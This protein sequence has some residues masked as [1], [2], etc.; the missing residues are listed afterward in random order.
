MFSPYVVSLEGSF[1]KIAIICSSK[2]EDNGGRRQHS[3]TIFKSGTIS[4]K[5]N[6]FTLES[7]VIGMFTVGLKVG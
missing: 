3:G 4:S 2:T 1:L 6:K 5:V 7:Q